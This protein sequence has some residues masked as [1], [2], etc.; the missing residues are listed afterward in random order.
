VRPIWSSAHAMAIAPIHHD[1]TARANAAPTPTTIAVRMFAAKT[2]PRSLCWYLRASYSLRTALR[3]PCHHFWADDVCAAAHWLSSDCVISGP[4]EN[5][6]V[7][8]RCSKSARSPPGAGS[9]RRKR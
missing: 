3:K 1:R 5:S 7:I 4:V 2:P 8:T 9:V 6:R